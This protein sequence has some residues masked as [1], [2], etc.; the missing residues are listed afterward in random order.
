MSKTGQ[1][2]FIS[3]LVAYMVFWGII[4]YI[5]VPK[6]HWASQKKKY[7]ERQRIEQGRTCQYAYIALIFYLILYL[8]VEKALHIVWCDP[9]FGIL[10]GIT[11][12]IAVFM[13]YCIFQDAYFCVNESRPV[14]LI[15]VNVVG[16]TQLLQGAESI[17]EGTIIEDGIITTDAVY[18]L[19]VALILLLDLFVFIRKRLDIPV[20]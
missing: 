2:V 20:S 6:E 1:I 19:F 4:I 16:L 13:A 18:F 7:D 11:L 3:V 10:L 15:T 12:S 8:F 14:S 17:A 5:G 9:V